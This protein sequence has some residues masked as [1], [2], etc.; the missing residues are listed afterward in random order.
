MLELVSFSILT[1]LQGILKIY[2]LT[3]E[4]TAPMHAQFN[5]DSANNRWNISSKA[6]REFVEHFGPGTEQLDIYFEDGRVSFTSYTD[7]VMSG[8]GK[9]SSH[10]GIYC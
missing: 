3:F 7:K 4:S 5:K 2:R 8:N 10:C 6:L 9:A 1:T